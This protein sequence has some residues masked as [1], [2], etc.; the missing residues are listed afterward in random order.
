M[1]K[2]FAWVYICA[3]PMYQVPLM[4][5]KGSRSLWKGVAGG[6]ER[7]R[8]CWE[9]NPGVLEERQTL[10]VTGLSIYFSRFYSEVQ[11]SFCNGAPTLTR[12]RRLF[13]CKDVYFSRV[14]DAPWGCRQNETWVMGWEERTLLHFR[15]MELCMKSGADWSTLV[16]AHCQW[17]RGQSS[18][19]CSH[20]WS[21]IPQGN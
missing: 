15:I 7:P 5:E 21:P 16:T 6:C 14:C 11:L 8:E 10:L 1:H 13:I 3:S 19:L 9:P 2:C 17:G 12:R 4:P 18:Q 20:Q